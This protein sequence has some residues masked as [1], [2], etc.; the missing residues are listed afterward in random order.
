MVRIFNPAR[1]TGKT[2]DGRQVWR[3]SDD[4]WSADRA[5]AEVIEDEAHCDIR[6]LDAEIDSGGVSEVRLESVE[7]LERLA[8]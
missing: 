2:S 6:L 7:A 3:T 4:R 5:Q 8:S 1:I